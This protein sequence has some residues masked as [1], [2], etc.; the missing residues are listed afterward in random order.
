MERQLDSLASDLLKQSLEQRGMQFLM[1]ATTERLVGSSRVESVQF[2]DGTRIDADLVVMSAGITPN[3][4]LAQR[5]ALHCERGIVVND[6]M[7]SFDPAIYAVGECA[8]H[9]GVVYGLV[10]PIV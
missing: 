10:A 1:G 7:Q 2:K 3:I 8:Q 5:A 9:R 6:V 4:T